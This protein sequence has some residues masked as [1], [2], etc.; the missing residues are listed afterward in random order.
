MQICQLPGFYKEISSRCFQYRFKYTSDILQMAQLTK[1]R[2]HR[3]FGWSDDCCCEAISYVTIETGSQVAKMETD[4]KNVQAPMSHKNLLN[5]N[6]ISGPIVR[7][8]VLQKRTNWSGFYGRE[9]VEYAFRDAQQRSA[10]LRQFFSQ[11]ST[12]NDSQ[13]RCF[14]NWEKEERQIFGERIGP[15]I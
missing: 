10:S 1:S 14:R 8:V 9:I 13:T 5:N 6:K 15:S 3:M 12:S 4:K 11:T 2:F 7:Q